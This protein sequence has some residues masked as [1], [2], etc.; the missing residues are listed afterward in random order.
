MSIIYLLV[1][2][3]VGL[4]RPGSRVT[5]LE[6]KSLAADVWPVQAP[7]HVACICIGRIGHAGRRTDLRFDPGLS[8]R[9]QSVWGLEFRMETHRGRRFFVAGVP[10]DC[11]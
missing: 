2:R 11:R 8:V 3:S 7:I 6:F 1:N 5:S 4:L 10:R 9:D